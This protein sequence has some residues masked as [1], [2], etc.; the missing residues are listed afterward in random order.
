[1]MAGLGQTIFDILMGFISF[2]SVFVL[3]AGIIGTTIWILLKL[4]AE[5]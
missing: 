1:M 3:F 2:G 4:A 5:E